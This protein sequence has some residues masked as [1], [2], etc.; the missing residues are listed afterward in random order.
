M[1]NRVTENGTRVLVALRNGRVLHGYAIMNAVKT[2][3]AVLVPIG[4]LYRTIA[5]LLGD[6]LIE[7]VASPM[8]DETDARRKY[9]RRTEEV[10][11]AAD[12]QIE[13][14]RVI[15]AAASG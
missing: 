4:S 14:Y 1:L 11:R 6:G 5:K 13:R 12:R 8:V 7:E 9:Y 10:G 2:D 15:V 3:T